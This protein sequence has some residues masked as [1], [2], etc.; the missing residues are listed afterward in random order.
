MLLQDHD[1]LNVPR[2]VVAV[3]EIKISAISVDPE[4]PLDS[5][6]H[7]IYKVSL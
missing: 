2:L 5:D 6:D 4:C 3:S 7:Y 1:S